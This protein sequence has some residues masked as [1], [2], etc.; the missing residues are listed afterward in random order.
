[1]AQCVQALALIEL[2]RL[3]VEGAPR[4]GVGVHHGQIMD[5]VDG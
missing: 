4:C 2:H 3:N 1:M 5:H